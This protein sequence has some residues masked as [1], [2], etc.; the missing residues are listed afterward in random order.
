MGQP[1]YYKDLCLVKD[2]PNKETKYWNFLEIESLKILFQREIN[3]YRLEGETIGQKL[4]M[5][6]DVKPKL[7]KSYQ[8]V[9][10]GFFCDI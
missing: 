6:N 9:S 8:T 10:L 3:S 7:S 1:T 4:Q 2:D 5:S